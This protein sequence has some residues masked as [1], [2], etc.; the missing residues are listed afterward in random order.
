MGLVRQRPQERDARI[1]QRRRDRAERLE[2]P[3]EAHR[4]RFGVVI[5][6][7]REDRRR[8]SGVGREELR[9][10]VSLL[11]VGIDDIAEVVEEPR[12]HAIAKLADHRRRNPTLRP[13]IHVATRVTDGVKAHHTG[14]S[15]LL[16]R[17]GPDHVGQQATVGR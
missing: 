9:T 7:N 11:P 12:R 13:R 10:V 15:D 8:I 3:A 2:K 17:R 16:R 1:V 14:A 4:W 5:A 6:R